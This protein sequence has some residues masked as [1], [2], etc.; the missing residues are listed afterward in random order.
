MLS[1]LSNF[2]RPELPDVPERKV[3]AHFIR[4]PKKRAEFET[5]G[6]TILENMVPEAVI[7]EVLEALE[8]IKKLPGYFESKKL[9]STPAFGE[10]AHRIAFQTINSVCGSI[11]PEHL[12]ETKCRFDFGGSIIIKNKGCWLEPHQ[13]SSVVDEYKAVTAYAWI[14]TVTMTQDNGTFYAIEGSHLWAAWQRSSQHPDWPLKKFEQ[15]LWKQMRP[16]QVNK[17]AALLFDSALIHASGSNRTDVP[18]IAFNT[19]I[20]DRQAQ[21]VQYVEQKDTP[22]GMVEKYLVDERFWNAGDFWG[23]PKGYPMILEKKIY[24]SRI[25]KRFLAAQIEK[26]RP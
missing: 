13:D 9:E 19:C 12:D 1:I 16:I 25:S 10:A 24:P 6:Y 15:F 4:D 17:G 23:R 8:Q 5:K 18:R 14:P 3:N 22:K 2:L 7:E 21:H 26:F 11:F 20:I